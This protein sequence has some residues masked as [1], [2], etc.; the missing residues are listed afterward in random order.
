MDNNGHRKPV[1][2]AAFD[3]APDNKSPA[4]SPGPTGLNHQLLVKLLTGL[5]PPDERMDVMFVEACI[6]GADLV[7]CQYVTA[8]KASDCCTATNAVPLSVALF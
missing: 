3:W 2:I 5:L 6:F 1:S 8:E 4:N 7:T